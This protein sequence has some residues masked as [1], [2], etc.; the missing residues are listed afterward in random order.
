MPAAALHDVISAA[1]R[2][3]RDAG[4]APADASADAD[5]LARHLLGWDRARLLARRLDAAPDGFAPALDALVAQRLH[6]APVAYLTGTREFYGLAFEVTPDV[7]IPR[8]ETELLVNAALD[9][10]AGRDAPRLADVGTGSGCIAVAIA[11]T[12]PSA[13]VFALDRSRAA[14]AVAR[15]NAARYGVAHRVPLC[16]ADLLTALAPDS[17]LDAIVS[18]PPY[19]PDASPDV[20]P[21]VAGH[22]PPLSLYA[23]P[24]GLDAIRRLI[25]DAPA[26]LRTGGR[27]LMEIGAGQAAA[28]AALAAVDGRW[29]AAEFRLD[30]QA[31]P[32]VAELIRIA[33]PDRLPS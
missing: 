29:T 18:N 31:I 33:D 21:D 24:D 20:M 27:L 8:P 13:V 2:R 23:G 1:A 14:V 3:L 22:E 16:A 9:A 10:V 15:R 19:V 28:V 26:R 6:R 17:G 5:V 4:F 7:L 32:R 30:L 12:R 11:A 25:R